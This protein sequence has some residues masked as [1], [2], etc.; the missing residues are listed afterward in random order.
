MLVLLP[1]FASAADNI[2]VLSAGEETGCTWLAQEQCSTEA[3]L[4][5]EECLNWHQTQA[6]AA[7][8]DALL[9][10][11][12]EESRRKKPSLTGMKTVVATKVSADYYRCAAAAATA[13]TVVKG[14]EGWST[15]EKR[16]L[17]LESLKA[18]GLISAEEYQAKRQDILKDL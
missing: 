18:K 9:M 8:A 12:S 2:R 4:A 5:A 3:R 11:D 17:V 7:G 13:E 15:V 14:A 16:L 1:C 6:V 10:G